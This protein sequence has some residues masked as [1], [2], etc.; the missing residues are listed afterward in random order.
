MPTYEEIQDWVKRNR[1]YQPKTCWIAHCRELNGL[2]VRSRRTGA[3]K[4]PC[5]SAKQQD[6]ADAFQHF[7]MI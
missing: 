2:Q 5:P 4:H 6:I 3:R 7:G 1:G